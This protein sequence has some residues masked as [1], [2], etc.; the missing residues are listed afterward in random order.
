MSISNSCKNKRDQIPK[1]FFYSLIWLLFIINS[2]VL[3]LFI[4]N[5]LYFFFF[6]LQVWILIF[7]LQHNKLSLAII[8]GNGEAKRTNNYYAHRMLQRNMLSEFLLMNK[9]K[10]AVNLQIICR[11][12]PKS[13]DSKYLLSQKQRALSSHF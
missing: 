9:N 11:G 7:N 1:G 12:N 6:A 10:E 2:V 13:Y 3:F 4:V 5:L 8:R